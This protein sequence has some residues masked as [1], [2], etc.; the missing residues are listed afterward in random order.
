[1]LVGLMDLDVPVIAA[2]TGEAF[3]H[4]ELALLADIVLAT[5]DAQFADRAHFATRGTVPGDGTHI[6]WAS[7]I[8]PSRSR[9]FLMTGTAIETEEARSIGFVH[10][11]H[12]A[13]ELYERAWELAEDL[14]AHG[15]PVLRYTKAAL[16]IPLRRD[17][18]DELSHG[19]ALQGGGYWAKGGI[20]PPSATASALVP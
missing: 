12:E 15:L 16:S 1:M 17:F 13:D 8:G 10:E 5:P 18:A 3:V 4:A 7:L 11:L 19:L 20:K 14:A 6:A 2:V 9:Y